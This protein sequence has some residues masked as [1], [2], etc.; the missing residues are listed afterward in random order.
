MADRLPIFHIGANKAGST[1]LQQALFARHPEVFNLGKPFERRTR[2]DACRAVD[3]V[4]ALCEGGASPQP[5]GSEIRDK[6]R[7]A[8]RPAEG[9]L[10][11]FSHEELIRRRYYPDNDIVRLP[12][13]I[14]QLAGPARVVI[15]TRHQIEL[16]ESLY[17]H[18]ANVATYQP[19]DRWLTANNE[20]IGTYR[21]HEI[22]DAWAKVVGDE[23]VGVF[24]FEELV[25]EPKSF[26]DRL[27]SFIGI[28][29]VEAAALLSDQ[30]KNARKS[31]RTQA[32]VKLR[33]KL[34]PRR[35]LSALLP[36]KIRA[37]WHEYLEGGVASREPLP[38]QW[39]AKIQDTY[40][41]DNQRLAERFGLPLGQYGY[42]L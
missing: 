11:V 34:L 42:P 17:I 27:C 19:F 26:A 22:A 24:L 3:A 6:W 18:K 23:N 16:I 12:N 40:R 14:V 20:W 4:C 38:D 39:L 32:Y 25:H 41:D 5:V 9:R 36:E 30:H 13:A 1:T 15:V 33:S 7:R 21:F 35:S 37:S 28:D 2:G 31:S 10:P 8:L 29:P